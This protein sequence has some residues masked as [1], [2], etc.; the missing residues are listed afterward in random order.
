MVGVRSVSD[1][2]AA[3]FGGTLLAWTRPAGSHPTGSASAFLLSRPFRRW[4]WRHPPPCFGAIVL[5]FWGTRNAGWLLLLVGL[6]CVVG[7]AGL[8][9][10]ALLR[11]EAW[12]GGPAFTP[13]CCAEQG[14]PCRLTAEGSAGPSQGRRQKQPH[15]RELG[16]G[17]QGSI[18]QPC[19]IRRGLAVLSAVSKEPT[20]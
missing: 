12:C 8:G 11:T 14:S 1:A 7:G 17:D 20:H 18:S 4:A 6:G 19:R 3:T 9:A 13:L 10:F 5:L 15:T 2:R 16:H